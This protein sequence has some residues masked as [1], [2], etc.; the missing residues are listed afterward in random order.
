MTKITKPKPQKFIII[1]DTSILWCTDK[2]H[3]VNPEFDEFWDKHSGI[4]QLELLIPEVVKGELLFQQTESAIKSYDKAC[5]LLEKVGLITKRKLK[6][7]TQRNELKERVETKFNNWVKKKKAKVQRTP[8]LSKEKWEA[9]IDN[10]IWRKPPFE[11]DTKI[12]DNEKGFRDAL[13]I[14]TLCSW[15]FRVLSG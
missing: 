6:I 15:R 7:N 8:L 2:S 1:P 10:S 11:E 12:S 9:L 3:A 14:E 13:I 5:E 4:I